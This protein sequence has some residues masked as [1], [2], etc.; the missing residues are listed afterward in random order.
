MSLAKIIIKKMVSGVKLHSHVDALSLMAAE[1]P[2]P[3]HY[4]ADNMADTEL[5]P[6][7]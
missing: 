5:L 3:S 2:V 7:Q 6:W 1:F 4:T